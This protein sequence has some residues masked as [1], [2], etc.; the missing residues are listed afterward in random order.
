MKKYVFAAFMIFVLAGCQSPRAVEFRGIENIHVAQT[1]L[2]NT[3]IAATLTFFNPNLF[4]IQVKR[5]DAD[6]YINND[7][8][9][10]YQLNTNIRVPANSLFNFDAVINM[11]TA[12]VLRNAYSTLTGKPV[13]IHIVGRIKVGR[14]LFAVNMPIDVHTQQ[15]LRL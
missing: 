11:A 10:H 2:N 12:S 4:N 1:A 3:T 6:M 8:I 13:D 9:T 7:Y 5:I 14:G 15:Q